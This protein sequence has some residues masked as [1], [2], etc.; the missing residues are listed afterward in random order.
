M[1]SLTPLAT[2]LFKCVSLRLSDHSCRFTCHDSYSVVFHIKSVDQDTGILVL[3][4]LSEVWSILFDYY[5][6]LRPFKVLVHPAA[7][8]EAQ[9]RAL[10][11]AGNVVSIIQ[12]KGYSTNPPIASQMSSKSRPKVGKKGVELLK[13]TS[14]LGKKTTESRMKELVKEVQ[15]VIV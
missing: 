13:Q 9:Y 1:K 6:M 5:A 14:A 15:S 3:D 7:D 2:L 10:V 8:G 11:A 12:Y 4:L